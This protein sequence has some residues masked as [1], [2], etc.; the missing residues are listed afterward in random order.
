[1]NI[2][3]R[4]RVYE[5][6][7]YSLL[8][9]ERNAFSFCKVD[10][11]CVNG[12]WCFSSRKKCESVSEKDSIIVIASNDHMWLTI[13]WQCTLNSETITRISIWMQRWII[14]L[15]VYRVPVLRPIKNTTTKKTNHLMKFQPTKNIIRLF[16]FFF[17]W[18]FTSF[19]SLSV[20][21]FVGRYKNW[22]F[23]LTG[24]NGWID[25]TNE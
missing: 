11:I 21:P 12:V 14:Y 13:T 18:F 5:I 2:N 20:D 16:N 10:F 19:F 25:S 15:F 22:F 6:F 4:F 1:M 8:K 7:I 24:K 17:R 23:F 9:E 3:N